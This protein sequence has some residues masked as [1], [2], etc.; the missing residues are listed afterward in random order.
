[1]GIAEAKMTFHHTKSTAREQVLATGWMF[2]HQQGLIQQVAEQDLT[3]YLLTLLIQPEGQRNFRQM[4]HPQ[5]LL[6]G[7]GGNHKETFTVPS[8]VT[9]G[10]GILS[11]LFL[12]PFLRTR[13]QSLKAAY[14]AFFRSGQ[15]LLCDGHG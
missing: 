8:D 11:P 13:Y 9:R 3:L 6:Y 2:P 7:E 1:M 10:E 4:A 15:E 14:R 5:A 12:L